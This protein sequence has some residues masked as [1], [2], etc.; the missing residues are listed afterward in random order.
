MAPPFLTH[1]FE[2]HKSVERV[3][4]NH[5]YST[6][7]MVEM[8]RSLPPSVQRL[9]IDTYSFLD[10][11]GLAVLTPAPHFPPSCPALRELV[12]LRCVSISDA[13]VLRFITARMAITPCPTLKRIEVQFSR[14][15]TLD[16]LP[17]LRPFVEAGEF[18]ATI[19][20]YP[21]SPVQFSP[22]QGLADASVIPWPSVWQTVE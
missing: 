16:M 11:D 13:A 9:E 12:I 1:F 14:P 10:D 19:S 3:S 22:W 8:L 7:H 6:S 4:I 5:A 20:H 15:R 2:A 18:T 17:H 21:S